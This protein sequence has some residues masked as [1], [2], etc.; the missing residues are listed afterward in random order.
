M[1]SS[2]TT[3]AALMRFDSLLLDAEKVLQFC[4]IMFDIITAK[5]TLRAS[6][7]VISAS[8]DIK[9]HSLVALFQKKTFLVVIPVWINN[10]DQEYVKTEVTYYKNSRS[11]DSD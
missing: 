8:T 1:M 2:A 7:Q 5:Q 6:F 11:V 4:E 10:F 9:L 3:A